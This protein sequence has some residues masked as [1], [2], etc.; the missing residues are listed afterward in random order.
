MGYTFSLLGG[1]ENAVEGVFGDGGKTA[2]CGG[3]VQGARDLPQD[4]I[5]IFYRHQECGAQGLTDRNRRPIRNAHQLPFQVEILP[6]S[7]GWTL[8]VWSGRE[9]LNLRPPGPELSQYKL[10]VL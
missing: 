2:I 7:P 3:T 8:E 10:Q 4:G 1:R 6:M 5:P 9:D